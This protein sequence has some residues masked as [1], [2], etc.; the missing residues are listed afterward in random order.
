MPDDKTYDSRVI[1]LSDLL[2]RHGAA[3]KLEG[4]TFTG[5][6]IYGPVIVIPLAGVSFNGCNFKVE[7]PEDMFFE[8]PEGTRKTGLIGLFDC[9]FTNCVIEGVAIAG[10]PE[11]LAPLRAG[12]N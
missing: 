3:P 8:M 5:C 9:A 10:T 6:Q 7:N 12:L 2:D 1:Y 4:F 11:G